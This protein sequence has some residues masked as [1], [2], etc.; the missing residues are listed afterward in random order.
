MNTTQKIKPLYAKRGLIDI[1][2]AP[3]YIHQVYVDIYRFENEVN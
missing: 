1:N 2:I 3:I